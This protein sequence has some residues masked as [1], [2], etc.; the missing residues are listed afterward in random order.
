MSLNKIATAPK[1]YPIGKPVTGRPTGPVSEGKRPTT[2]GQDTFGR[3]GT[4]PAGAT[5]HKSQRPTAPDGVGQLLP[6]GI[7]VAPGQT[8][9][10]EIF[11]GKKVEGL[12]AKKA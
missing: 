11:E 1:T 8:I 2:M 4:P 12:R 7:P 5:I 3:T 9:E 10:G 6:Y